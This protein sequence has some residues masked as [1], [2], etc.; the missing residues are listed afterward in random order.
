MISAAVGTM[1]ML[2]VATVRRTRVAIIGFY[3]TVVGCAVEFLQILQVCV[4]PKFNISI[5]MRSND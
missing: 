3:H 4:W 5:R 1:F 2:W